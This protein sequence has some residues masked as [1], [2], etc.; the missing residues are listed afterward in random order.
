MRGF[1]HWMRAVFLSTILLTAVLL[2]AVLLPAGMAVADGDQASTAGTVTGY[3]TAAKP[4]RREMKAG[5]ETLETIPAFTAL[6]IQ[7][8]E[9]YWGT[10]T[11]PSGNMGYVWYEELVLLPE[12]ESV[13]PWNAV[14][15]E[16]RILRNMP[17]KRDP[18]NGKIEAGEMV[19]VDGVCGDYLH[20]RSRDGRTGYL[21]A[22]DVREVS[23]EPE[24]T[25][26]TLLC[27]GRETSAWVMPM[28]GAE[29]TTA[30]LPGVIYVSDARW[31]NYYRLA[32]DTEGWVAGWDVGIWD[33]EGESELFFR[34]PVED[35]GE[36]AIRPEA[37]FHRATVKEGGALFTRPDGTTQTLPAGENVYVFVSYGGFCGVS[38]HSLHGYIPEDRLEME[39]TAAAEARVRPYASLAS[40]ERS[41]ILDRALSLLEEGNAFLTRYNAFTGAAVEPL[42]SLG[43]PY[44]WGGRSYNILTERWPEYTT[45]EAWQSSLNY[46]RKGT[47]YLYGF[48]CTGLVRCILLKTGHAVGDSIRDLGDYRYC[49]QHHVWCSLKKPLPEDWKEIAEGLEVGD[50]LQVHH[51]NSHVMMYIGTLRDFGYTEEQ[52][53]AL[54]G[55]L[56]DPLMIQSGE[57]PAAYDR[58]HHF[59]ALQREGRLSWAE[60]PPDGGASICILGLH[61][62]D[63]E[64]TLTAHGSTKACFDVEGTCITVFDFDDVTNYFIYR[65]QPLAAE[66]G[67]EDAQRASGEDG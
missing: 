10:W 1:Q 53:P 9:R 23:F 67:T 61:R 28:N 2:T 42:F 56:D 57:N 60:V 8:V 47:V 17:D 19:T 64:M 66:E 59:L 26:R 36:D 24:E 14:P 18:G 27:V 65:D 31:K 5:S 7:P 38:S 12:T 63:A 6:D 4:L 52:L 22:A 45:R 62:E 16:N 46:Y 40:V 13:T 39:E 37:V 41:D 25:E 15:T 51:P 49:A 21:R 44:F 34:Q 3:F 32:G 48:D 50:V 11:S 54:A 35:G 55:A 43:V 20:V 58:F 29:E 33:V 30:L